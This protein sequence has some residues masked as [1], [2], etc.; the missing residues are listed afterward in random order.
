MPQV[1]SLKDNKVMT[2]YTAAKQIRD[3][4][5]GIAWPECLRIAARL[6]RAFELRASRARLHFF[7]ERSE[8]LKGERFRAALRRAS[9]LLEGAQGR[10]GKPG[11]GISYH[12]P[13][14][15]ASNWWPGSASHLSPSF[16]RSSSSRVS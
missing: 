14:E 6:R 1:Y 13:S 11:M 10:E 9:A 8:R 15:P 12:P 2:T 7:R 5:L 16:E 4:K 3:Q